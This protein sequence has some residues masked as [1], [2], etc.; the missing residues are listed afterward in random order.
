MS[1]SKRKYKEYLSRPS[2]KIPRA[3]A[4]RRRKTE[5]LGGENDLP[6]D[7][8]GPERDSGENAP[9]ELVSESHGSAFE[10][11]PSNS[12]TQY[13]DLFHLE[14][15]EQNITSGMDSVYDVEHVLEDICEDDTDSCIHLEKIDDEWDLDIDLEL[16]E[17]EPSFCHT[18]P[19]SSLS[20]LTFRDL[21]VLLVTL[22][23]TFNLS[24][25]ALNFIIK[26]ISLT[27]PEN[28]RQHLR[29]V[30]Q[31]YSQFCKK[32]TIKKHSYCQYC[33]YY[34]GSDITLTSCP[35]C[36][37]DICA[38]KYFVELPLETELPKVLERK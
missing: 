35:T 13:K 33:A 16:E 26:I 17:M 21:S 25:I 10:F 34:I 3:T 18:D 11:I 19:I 9:N 4:S 27:L 5:V 20:K 38:D 28:K 14:K 15:C 12:N 22:K 23:V 8:L 36:E 2:S 32:D 29:N 37:K 31:L 24:A 1:C 7:S 6:V 30:N